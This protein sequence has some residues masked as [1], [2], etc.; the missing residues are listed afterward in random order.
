MNRKLDERVY[1]C[2]YC[3][4]CLFPLLR[5]Y[6]WHLYAVQTTGQFLKVA[7]SK[8]RGSVTLPCSTVSYFPHHLSVRCIITGTVQFWK[9]LLRISIASTSWPRK[10]YSGWNTVATVLKYKG[11]EERMLATVS[12]LNKKRQKWNYQEA[13]VVWWLLKKKTTFNHILVKSVTLN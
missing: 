11:S 5:R 7:V 10:A 4:L 12:A 8:K 1:F 6:S 3:V 13:I 9:R 2:L